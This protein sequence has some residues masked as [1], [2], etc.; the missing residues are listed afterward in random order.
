MLP[1]KNDTDTN[2]GTLT[3]IAPDKRY[4]LRVNWSGF[5]ELIMKKNV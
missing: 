1:K 4:T 3:Q 2:T 5:K